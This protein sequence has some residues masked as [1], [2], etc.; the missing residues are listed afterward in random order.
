V[1]PHLPIAHVILIGGLAAMAYSIAQPWGKSASGATLFIRDFASVQLNHGTT[2]NTAN[3]AVQ[4]ATGIV[5][6]AAALSAF[7]VLFNTILTLINKVVGVVGLGG[8]ATLIF[9]PV[10]WG[11]AT[12]LFLVLLASAGF[13]GLGSLS[14]LPI[15]A[16]NGISTAQ[17]HS[18]A[19]GFYLWIGGAIAVFVGMLGEVVLRR[20]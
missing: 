20:R 6:A 19:L 12:L 7:L 13:A 10:L 18:H 15:V 9:F 16:N 5:I 1:L 17:V 14:N 3:Y 8:C 4:A 2:V 11:A